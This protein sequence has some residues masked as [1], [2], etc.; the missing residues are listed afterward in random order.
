MLASQATLS[1]FENSV[2][3]SD[4][5]WMGVDLCESVIARHRRRA[6][7]RCRRINVDLDVTDDATHGARQL[8][9]FNGFYDS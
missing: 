8:S 5:Y 2:S 9:F 1:R 7:R 4:L 6:G 3:S